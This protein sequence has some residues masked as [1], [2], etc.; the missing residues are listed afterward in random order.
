MLRSLFRLPPSW[1]QH[2]WAP[3]EIEHPDT[4][5][6]ADSAAAEESYQALEQHMLQ[7]LAQGGGSR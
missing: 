3:T 2:A 5:I 7:R 6:L 4:V 1:L